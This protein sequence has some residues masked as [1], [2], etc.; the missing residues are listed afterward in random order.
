MQ[1]LNSLKIW[2]KRINWKRTIWNY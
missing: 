1:F 2:I